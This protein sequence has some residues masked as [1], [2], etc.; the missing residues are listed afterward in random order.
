MLDLDDELNFGKVVESSKGLS[1]IAYKIFSRHVW[2]TFK[3]ELRL[4]LI[5]LK[6]RNVPRR[7]R[8]AKDLLV[9]LASGSTGVAG[10]TNLDILNTPGVNCLFDCR[11]RLPFPD[12]SVKAIFCEHFL[13]HLDYTEETPLFLSECRRVLTAGG[14]LRIVVPDGEAY[15][16]AYL[17][18]GWDDMIRLRP[19]SEDRQ[20]SYFGCQY[21]TKMELI[22]M[23]FRQGIEHKYCYDYETL[24]YLLGQYGFGEVHRQ[25]YDKSL[26]DELHIDMPTRAPESLY[27]EAVR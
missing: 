24:R 22:N 3:Y 12:G 16:R 13:E 6:S 14:V 18:P 9:N 11:K 17:D 10:W 25:E 7:F 26:L 5:R 21:Q 15:L 20:D 2:L 4:A 27:V 1:L 8:G 23:V 19:L